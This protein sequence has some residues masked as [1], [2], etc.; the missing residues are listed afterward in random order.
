MKYQKVTSLKF[1]PIECPQ[2]LN[3]RVDLSMS[4]SAYK[5][6]KLV[7]NSSYANFGVSSVVVVKDLEF[8]KSGKSHQSDGQGD[9]VYL[10]VVHIVLDF[11]YRIGKI[12]M[13][14]LRREMI[15]GKRVVHQ[16]GTSHDTLNL[17]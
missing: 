9:G 4:I 5:P 8:S 11:S 6:Y 15:R 17:F 1:E 10:L 14:R 13:Q 12:W 7:K 2:L 3:A 16:F